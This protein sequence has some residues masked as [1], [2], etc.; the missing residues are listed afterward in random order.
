MEFEFFWI[1]LDSLSFQS[2]N[3]EIIELK[4]GYPLASQPRGKQLLGLLND[5]FWNFLEFSGFVSNYFWNPMKNYMK[6]YGNSNWILE[7]HNN[8]L[9]T[10]ERR[11]M[12]IIF[13]LLQTLKILKKLIRNFGSFCRK[14][15][16]RGTSL[17]CFQL[18]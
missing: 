17:Y 11:E 1:Q 16:T 8:Y 10:T 3:L 14:L 18:K 13:P 7:L 5:R 4:C 9:G 6:F 15:E 2:R 12:S